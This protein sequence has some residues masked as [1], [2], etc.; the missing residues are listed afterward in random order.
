MIRWEG[1]IYIV[2]ARALLSS[3]LSLISIHSL[4]MKGA[5]LNFVIE[6]YQEEVVAIPSEGEKRQE[7]A[8]LSRQKENDKHFLKK[9]QVDKTKVSLKKMK[10][11]SYDFSSNKPIREISSRP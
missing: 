6:D 11:Q 3:L 4:Q 9:G 2:V 1:G 7:I 8:Y 5:I 10:D